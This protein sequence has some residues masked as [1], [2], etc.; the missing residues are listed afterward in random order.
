M[1]GDH[2]CQDNRVLKRHSRSLTH[3]RRHRVTRVAEES[4][5]AIEP[6]DERRPLVYRLHKALVGRVDDLSDGGMERREKA[7]K[8]LLPARLGPRFAPPLL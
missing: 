2:P 1:L 4:G 3:V 6:G 8:V 7:S 5:S